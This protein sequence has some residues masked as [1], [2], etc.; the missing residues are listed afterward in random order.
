[1]LV[2]G[3]SHKPFGFHSAGGGPLCKNVLAV[4]QREN[5][6]SLDYRLDRLENFL[7]A[8]TTRPFHA[9]DRVFGGVALAG[10]NVKYR[11]GPCQLHAYHGSASPNNRFFRIVCI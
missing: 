8:V 3:R 2:V 11:K 10:D 9:L 4:L 5:Q 6:R 1:M 7:T